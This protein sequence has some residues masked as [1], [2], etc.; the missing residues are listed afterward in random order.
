MNFALGGFLAV[1]AHRQ[2]MQASSAVANRWFRDAVLFGTLIMLPVGIFFYLNWPDWSWLY[3]VDPARVGEVATVA[4]WLCYP[5]AVALG[6]AMTAVFIRGD[7]PRTCLAVPLIG[8]VAL[9]TVSGFG[10]DRF[11]RTANY[12]DYNN[13]LVR[14]RGLPFIW[15][16][17]SWVLTMAGTGVLAGIA[18][19]YLA[20][21]NLRE[22]GAGLLPPAKPE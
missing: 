16:D 6:F 20:V 1:T 12:A 4:V 10:Y 7:S 2:L 17:T 3:W 15:T 22:G 18:V 19:G 13:L 21:R 9:L 14:L 11:M 8:V 5:I